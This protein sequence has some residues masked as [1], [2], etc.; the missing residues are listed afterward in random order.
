MLEMIQILV[1]FSEVS[2]KYPDNKKRKD[3]EVSMLSWK[4]MLFI[5]IDKMIIWKKQ[6]LGIVLKL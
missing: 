1:I 5:K 4:K 2:L 3:K 6:N